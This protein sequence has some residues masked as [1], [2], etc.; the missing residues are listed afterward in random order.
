MIRTQEWETL[1]G[2]M[3]LEEKLA[4]LRD[5]SAKKVAEEKRAILVGAVKDL[6]ASGIMDG[7]IKVGDTLPPFA[8]KNSHG[9]EV[10]SAGLLAQ[11]TVVLTV[12]RGH[13]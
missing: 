11:G 8:L 10:T 13:W 2:V 3:S 6:M 9:A 4:Q 1:R 12:F 5:A 7:V